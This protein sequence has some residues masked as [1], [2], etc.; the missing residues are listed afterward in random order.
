[1]NE[2]T[3]APRSGTAATTDAFWLIL[4]GFLSQVVTLVLAILLRK[5]LGP[6]GMGY[7]AWTQLVASYAPYLSLGA[8]GAAER[9]IPIAIARGDEEEGRSLE[10]AG[11]SIALVVSVLACAALFAIGALRSATDGLIG[12]ALMCA[13]II[14][15]T[16]QIAIWATVRLRTRLRFTAFAWSSAA[17]AVAGSL[18][19]VVGALVWGATGALAGLVVGTVMQAVLLYKVARIGGLTV[20]R[21]RSFRRLAVLSP[22][23]LASGVTATLLQSVDQLAVGF[24][25]GTTSLGLYSAAY[26]GNG[27]A[28]RVPTLIGTVI[29][30]RLQRELGATS[31]EGRVFAMASRTTAALAIAMPVLV[32]GFLVALPALVFLALPGYRDAI[33]PMRLLLI[34]VIGLAFGMPAAHYLLTVDRQWRVVGITVLILAVMAL[35]YLAAGASGAMSLE[36]AAGVDIAAYFASGIVTQVAA[37]RVARQPA[38]RLL[39]LMPLYLLP[40]MELLVGAAVADTLMPRLSLV[41]VLLNAGLQACLFGV[42]WAVLVWFYLRA[43]PESR[44]DIRMVTE[45]VARAG[46]RLRAALTQLRTHA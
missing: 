19:P 42:T 35:A 7:V 30:P 39:P 17:G 45:L 4:T 20:P 22:A 10:L 26:L 34:G 33:G 29:Y 40:A 21:R 16:Q 32:A 3:E 24:I 8:M 36:V 2:S 43:R 44:A 6:A 5:E 14:L 28:L 46:G 31:D 13:S 11:V 25:L 18:L 1:V 37:Y 23:F 9:E 15:L 38:S 41:G 12:A 27:F